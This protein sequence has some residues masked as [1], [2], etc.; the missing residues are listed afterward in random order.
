MFFLWV[1]NNKAATNKEKIK[2]VWFWF[3]K[4]M[5]KKK[6]ENINMK[7]FQ[8]ILMQKFILN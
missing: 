5:F 1:T 7:I 3:F 8:M 4:M 6:I 2:S